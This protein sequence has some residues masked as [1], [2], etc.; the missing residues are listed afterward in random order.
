MRRSGR[1][2]LTG[3]LPTSV[4]ERNAN[5]LRIILGN[6]APE[7]TALGSSKSHFTS[8]SALVR[9]IRKPGRMRVPSQVA[10][11]LD[12]LAQDLDRRI[13]LFYGRQ[14]PIMRDARDHMHE[15]FSDSVNVEKSLPDTF[16]PLDFCDTLG[17]DGFIKMLF[18]AHPKIA[19]SQSVHADV[20]EGG[21]GGLNRPANVRPPIPRVSCLSGQFSRVQ[22]I[23]PYVIL[24]R[25]DD[26][27]HRSISNGSK[28]NQVKYCHYKANSEAASGRPISS[29]Q[30][31]MHN[32]SSMP[33]I[34]VAST[35]PHRHRA[36]LAAPSVAGAPLD[37]R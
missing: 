1:G 24:N 29:F 11:S 26:F 35:A 10:N 25:I 13:G 34:Q 18:E 6:S 37:A 7:H 14:E 33:I 31:K 17:V 16:P 28:S 32:H 23:R 2:D 3:V 8:M 27:A 20:L 4:I 22:S 9:V 19:C 36:F 5:C 30:E 12:T 21:P 15:F